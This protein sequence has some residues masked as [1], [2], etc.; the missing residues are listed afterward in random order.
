MYNTGMTNTDSYASEDKT[1]SPSELK[2]VLLNHKA[3]LDSNGQGGERANLKDYRLKGAVLLGADLRN[4]N[5]EG[6][7]LYGAYLKNS[8]LENCNLQGANLRGANL[9]WANLKNADLK[10]AN[11]MRAD[12]MQ[13]DIKNVRFEGAN[14]KMAEGL[15]PEQLESA[16]TDDDTN[17]PA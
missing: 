5:L 14:L 10:N 9:R 12:L 8:N 15:T 4:A 17:L 11:L 16:H 1:I 2:T 7:Y 6:A 13:A 3:W